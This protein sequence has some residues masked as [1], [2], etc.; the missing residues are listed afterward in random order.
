MTKDN[1]IINFRITPEAKEKLQAIKNLKKT[2]NVSSIINGL[3]ID[4]KEN[5]SSHNH[6]SIRTI[7]EVNLEIYTSDKID[8]EQSVR[9]YSR[10]FSELSIKRHA[11]IK[12][13][14]EKNGMGYFYFPINEELYVAII[15]CNKEEASIQFQKY[16]IYDKEEKR[17]IRTLLPL[18]QYR[19]DPTDKNI[20]IIEYGE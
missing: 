9:L 2:T 14:L 19:Y 11:E 10:S 5:T 3:L 16:Y 4:Y 7:P 18:P 1:N 6:V 15:A 8:I 17:Y 13:I 12:S 20:I